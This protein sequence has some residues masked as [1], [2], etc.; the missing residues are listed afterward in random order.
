MFPYLPRIHSRFSR[1]P[2]T[3]WYILES[4]AVMKSQCLSEDTGLHHQQTSPPS[5]DLYFLWPFQTCW[6]VCDW[7]SQR[8]NEDLAGT[9]TACVPRIYTG[10]VQGLGKY[11]WFKD[12]KKWPQLRLKFKWTVTT[13]SWRE[14]LDKLHGFAW[15]YLWEMLPVPEI[16]NTTDNHS[17]NFFSKC[18]SY[19]KTRNFFSVM[20][21]PFFSQEIIHFSAPQDPY[22]GAFHQ[23]PV[24]TSHNRLWSLDPT[25][26]FMCITKD[27]CA[28]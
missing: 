21:L 6:S 17:N 28:S 8:V 1:I 11:A 9:Q 18:L 4:G 16:S 15:L 25:Q 22:P 12:G 13:C 24:P 20:C 19:L 10:Q 7:N 27:F 5:L 26:L 14:Q 23:L 2:H 3:C